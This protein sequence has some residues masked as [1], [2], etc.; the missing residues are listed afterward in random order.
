MLW[1]TATMISE[2]ARFVL[3]AERSFLP[4]A[5]LCRR[6]GISRPTGHKW[7]SR[8][9]AEGLSALEDGSHRPHFCPHLTPEPV[10]A[11]ILQVR[12]NGEWG[13]P[14]IQRILRGPWRPSVRRPPSRL[15]WIG[16]SGESPNRAGRRAIPAG[17]FR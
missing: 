3:E 12:C 9:G 1:K 5:K 8:H 2:R 13:A 17:L 6:H 14:K 7:P 15:E 16:S 10:V 4:F 11:R